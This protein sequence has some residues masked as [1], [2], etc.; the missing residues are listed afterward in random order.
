MNNYIILFSVKNCNDFLSVFINLVEI[1]QNPL[2]VDCS[3]RYNKRK[4]GLS[5]PIHHDKAVYGKLAAS[6]ETLSDDEL[7]AMAQSLLE[8]DE[9][10]NC[11]LKG[12]KVERK[13]ENEK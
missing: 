6:K 13:M 8:D 10:E 3:L 11:E 12:K 9:E 2:T 5:M 7:I 4:R 1:S